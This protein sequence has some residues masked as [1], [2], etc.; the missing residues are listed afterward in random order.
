MACVTI[1]LVI[2]KRTVLLPDAGE[3][4]RRR[5][6]DGGGRQWRRQA[7]GTG[8]RAPLEFDAR[9]NFS[10]YF[11]QE[12]RIFF[13]LPEAFCCLK[14]AENAIAHDAPPDPL[15]GCGADT[16]PHTHPLGAFWRL[17]AR[18]FGASFVVPP[19]TKSWRRHWWA[20]LMSAALQPCFLPVCFV[21]LSC[22]VRSVHYILYGLY[23]H[24]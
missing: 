9:T 20:G 23:G 14:Y 15:V 4:R 12:N 3:R 19:D 2:S 11:G 6:D 18:A 17:D 1:P 8:A 24:G 7:W 22:G 10:L 5:G 16:P 21:T 13:L